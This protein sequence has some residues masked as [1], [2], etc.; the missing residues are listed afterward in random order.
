VDN[1]IIGV[2]MLT[3][4]SDV[5]SSPPVRH[6]MCRGQW[7][8]YYTDMSTLWRQNRWR[9]SARWGFWTPGFWTLT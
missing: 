8:L 7:H 4:V 2:V 3:A 6:M 9:V 1:T 5:A